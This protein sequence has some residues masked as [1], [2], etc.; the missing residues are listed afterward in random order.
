MLNQEQFPAH[1]IEAAKNWEGSMSMEMATAAAHHTGAEGWSTGRQHPRVER[2]ARHLVEGA[3]STG[4]TLFSGHAVPH[5]QFKEGESFHVPLMA[6]S[7]WREVAEGFSQPD[8]PSEYDNPH[9]YEFR[10][11]RG[12][13]VNRHEVVVTG[14]YKVAKVNPGHIVFDPEN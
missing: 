13:P 1:V 3:Q 9:I 8:E 4:E 2:D 11:A 7:R 14:R 12:V 10:G 5:R 6:A